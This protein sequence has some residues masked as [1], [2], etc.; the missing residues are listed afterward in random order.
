M[1]RREAY[2]SGA[3]SN[4]DLY[5]NYFATLESWGLVKLGSMNGNKPEKH[6]QRIERMIVDFIGENLD[7]AI[8][9]QAREQ[10]KASVRARIDAEKKNL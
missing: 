3:R 1:K 7:Q 2:A 5:W 4:Y 6:L 10:F 9:L 8:E